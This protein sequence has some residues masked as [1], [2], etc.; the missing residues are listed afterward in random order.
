LPSQ[1][2]FVGKKYTRHPTTTEF[3]VECVGASKGLLE[4]A[5]LFADRLLRWR[6]ARQSDDRVNLFG[7]A[8]Q[9]ALGWAVGCSLHSLLF[10]RLAA[11]LL[12]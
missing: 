9:V 10:D 5:R 4:V 2:D 1:R 12:A 3:P 8:S 7:P 11:Q 6:I